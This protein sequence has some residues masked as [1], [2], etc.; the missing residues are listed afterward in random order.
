M[1]KL[2]DG[3]IQPVAELFDGGNGGTIVAAADDIVE[4][5]LRDTTESCEFV[6]RDFSLVA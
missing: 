6:D 5:G 1:E 2:D 3:D 4:C